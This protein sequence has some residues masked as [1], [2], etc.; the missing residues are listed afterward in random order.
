MSALPT[1]RVGQ[2]WRDNDPRSKLPE[3]VI[4]DILP[5]RVRVVRTAP[6]T[7]KQYRS[8]I[9]TTRLFSTGRRGYRLL[10]E[11]SLPTEPRPLATSPVEAHGD[12]V[13]GTPLDIPV[14][15]RQTQQG[16]LVVIG[17][18]PAVPG[19]REAL[20]EM[21]WAEAVG[22]APVLI[23][24]DENHFRPATTIE[25]RLITAIKVALGLT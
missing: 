16:M 22:V 13:G 17:P 23:L 21:H 19:L 10:A 3:F 24:Y 15:Q 12:P 8:F 11:P 7:G 4:E 25:I 18:F 5:F 14:L 6:L 2:R 20:P 9:R 1:I